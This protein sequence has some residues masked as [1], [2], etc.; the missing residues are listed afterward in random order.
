MSHKREDDKDTNGGANNNNN[1][2]D[3][4]TNG[5]ANYNFHVELSQENYIR[6][7][8]TQ[9]KPFFDECNLELVVINTGEFYRYPL[10]GGSNK[11]GDDKPKKYMAI[12]FEEKEENGWPALRLMN[13]PSFSIF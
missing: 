1:S 2:L 3:S 10:P 5:T 7:S 4:S 6:F 13:G 9:G 11:S 12:W 8:P